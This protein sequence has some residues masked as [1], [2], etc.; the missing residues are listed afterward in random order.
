[1]MNRGG[2][3]D[4]VGRAAEHIDLNAKPEPAVAE[5]PAPPAE[6]VIAQAPTVDRAVDPAPVAPKAAP[7]PLEFNWL[8]LE[9]EGFLTPENRR[10]L[11]AEE[12]RLIKRPLLRTAFGRDNRAQRNG[13]SH[14]AMVT[15][16]APGDGKTFTAVNLALSIAS[17]RDLSVLLI[18][19]DARRM[20]LSR[21]LGAAGRKGLIDVLMDPAMSLSDVIVRTDVP[22][23][24]VVPAGQII[25]APTEVFA[26]QSMTRM[27]TDIATR[28]PN[29]FILFDAP[30][31][32]ASSEAGVLAS[33]VGQVIMV[34]QANET[35][36]QAVAQAL[37]LV[38]ACPH[39]SFVLNRVTMS[40]GM[41]RFGRYSY[42]QEGGDQWVG[43]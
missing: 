30:P 27:M 14:I 10:S 11:T 36:R 15:S 13:V 22:N 5:S 2:L 1:M 17:E 35:S 24:S 19:G 26:S 9:R 20:G 6:P 4:L 8:H 41:D 31:A 37:G 16:P 39:I 3:I 28:Y 32:L 40:A 38:D 25:D 34:V 7:T 18:D 23:L 21:L 33:H 29:R 42:H 12:F 43:S